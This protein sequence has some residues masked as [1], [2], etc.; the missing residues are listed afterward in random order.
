MKRVIGISA[1]TLVAAG[2]LLPARATEVRPRALEA[3]A[4]ASVVFAIGDVQPALDPAIADSRAASTNL[5]S[6]ALDSVAWPGFL[7]DAFFF[8][9]GFQSVER[10]GLGIAEARYPQGPTRVDATQS[11]LLFANGG[12]AESVP[13]SAGRSRAV[14]GDGNASGDVAIV[15]AAIA[16]GG[17]IGHGTSASGVRTAGVEAT[18]GARQALDDVT[19]G[20]L[21]I[22]AIRGDASA[23]AG[24]DE[25]SFSSH[26]VV[27]GATV[28]GTPVTIDGDGV[29]AQ[30]AALQRQV[31]DAL[32]ASGIT[33][34]LVPASQSHDTN[35]A[36]VSSGGVLLG[37]TVDAID[38]TG[39]P[40]NAHVVYLLGSATVTVRSAALTIASPTVLGEHFER[41]VMTT[42]TVLVPQSPRPRIA[43]DVPA[44]PRHR[45]RVIITETAAGV[46][47]SARGAYA[48]LF[49]VGFGLL[50]IRPLVRAASR[51]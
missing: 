29:R 50:L 16:G 38:P 41:P 45:R 46:A 31:D 30:T 23:S 1:A 25:P 14:A 43:P 9:Y 33:A 20:P 2:S 21:S 47:A 51:A 22:E 8:L 32:R 17:T 3:T 11:N 35:G 6:S 7:P 48:F 34:S 39:T 18:G 4:R 10:V 24:A 44:A 36:S 5:G 37:V 49:L 27:A 19:V 28:A 42:R 13:G 12:S 15:T 40:R 26:L